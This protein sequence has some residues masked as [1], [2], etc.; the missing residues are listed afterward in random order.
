MCNIQVLMR[1]TFQ[2]GKGAS[3]LIHEATFEDDLLALAK[4]RRH[5]TTQEAIGIAQKMN[6]EFTILT[7]FSQRNPKVPTA[8]CN[9]SI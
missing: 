8:L 7:H 5:C 1:H 2:A 6:A 3:L 4:E 9:H